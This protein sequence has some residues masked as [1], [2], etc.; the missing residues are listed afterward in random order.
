MYVFQFFNMN[1]ISLN[2]CKLIKVLNWTSVVIN[3]KSI[4]LY[5]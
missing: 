4:P 1:N 5:T 2:C 3:T